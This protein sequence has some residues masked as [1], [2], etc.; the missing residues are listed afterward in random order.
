MFEAYTGETKSPEE[1]IKQ[2]EA[3]VK[4]YRTEAVDAMQWVLVYKD[5]PE[6]LEKLAN[7]ILGQFD[8][9]GTLIEDNKE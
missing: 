4:F 7:H 9:H 1:R 3:T 2:L 6:M 5:D 8:P